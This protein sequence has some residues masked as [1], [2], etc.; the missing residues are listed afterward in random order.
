[1]SR[2]AA[3][4]A[5]PACILVA[6]SMTG[7]T[8]SMVLAAVAEVWWPVLSSAGREPELEAHIS[9]RHHPGNGEANVFG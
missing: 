6:R 5:P 2:L 8:R 4:L 3:R 9:N 1:M 7:W